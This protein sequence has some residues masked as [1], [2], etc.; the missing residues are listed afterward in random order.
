[1]RIRGDK[2]TALLLRRLWIKLAQ[3]EQERWCIFAACRCAFLFAPSSLSRY[4]KRGIHIQST[5]PCW[6][7]C[8]FYTVDRAF[9]C[10][11]ACKSPEQQSLTYKYSLEITSFFAP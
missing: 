6:Q 2:Q 4:L 1:M 7:K 11:K 8:H 10:S 9:C 3:P 5:S